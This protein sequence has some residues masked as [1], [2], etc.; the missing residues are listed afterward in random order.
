MIYNLWNYTDQPTCPCLVDHKKE[1]DEI[2]EK[3]NLIDKAIAANVDAIKDIDGE[4]KTLSE[5]NNV[6]KDVIDNGFTEKDRKKEEAQKDIMESEIVD[7][8]RTLV[9]KKCRYFNR[10]YCKYTSKCRFSHPREICQTYLEGYNCNQ[11]ECEKR[12][13]KSCKW[14]EGSRSCKRQNCAYL[15]TVIPENRCKEANFKCEGCTTVWDKQEFVVKHMIQNTER[16]FC[17][18]CED[19]IKEKDKVFLSGWSLFDDGGFLRH[20]V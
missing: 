9:R 8:G 1:I 14:I 15:H 19:W 17:L 6:Q 5:G 4:I 7:A 2:M 18:N 11:R 20:D 13:P 16:D 10:G 3:Q 12:H